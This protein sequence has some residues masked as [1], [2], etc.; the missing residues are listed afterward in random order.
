MNKLNKR[1]LSWNLIKA[2]W[3]KFKTSWFTEL[4]P[5]DN[6]NKEKDLLYFTNTLLNIAERHILKS[7]TSSKHN[8]PWFNEEYQKALRLRRAAL[9]KFKRNPT[10]ENLNNYKNSRAKAQKIIKDS[11]WST[12]KNCFALKN[13]T[14]PKKV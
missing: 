12:W 10:R 14:K 9:K 6:K 8:R 11:Q 4:I 3:D 2:N 5:E 1:T 13:S 7:S